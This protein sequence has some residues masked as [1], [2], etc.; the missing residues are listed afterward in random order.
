MECIKAIKE[1]RSIRKFKNIEIEKEIIQELLDAAQWAPSA[2]NLQARDFVVVTRKT[3]KNKLALAALGQNFIEE[4]PVVIVAVA[5]IGRSSQRYGE[6]GELYA[7][8]DT[9]ASVMNILLAAH[10]KGLAT[11][12]VG[13]FD[14]EAVSRLL[15]LPS[16]TRPIAIIPIG[17]PDE[18][19]LAP[20]RMNLNDVVHWETW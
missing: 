6:R 9:T 2:G 17:Y 11:C 8:Q 14:E 13:A 16:K 1:R 20:P 12:W 4:A 15:G 3:T 19:P 5:N 7:L 10:A 18:H